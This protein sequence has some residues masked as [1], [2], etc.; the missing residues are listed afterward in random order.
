MSVSVAV[1]GATGRL[2]RVVCDVVDSMSGFELVARL[3]SQDSLDEVGGADIVVDV[4]IPAASESVVQ[5][6]LEHGA[7]VLVGTSGWSADRLTALERTLEGEAA[8]LVVPNFSVGSVVATALSTLAA[9]YFDSVEII[10]AHHQDKIDSPSGTARR[11]AEL[12]AQERAKH[13]GVVSPHSNQTARGEVIDGIPVH[14]LR[15]AGVVA[16]QDVVFGGVAETL[17]IRHD[18]HSA[19]A[20]RQGIE[21]ALRSLVNQT[22]LVVGLHSALGLGQASEQ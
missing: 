5:A 16:Q 4:T 11:T 1:V 6:G 22:G 21:L 18:T 13:G 17:T 2:G 12:I 20:Y 14:S 8:V 19:E 10:E 7:K 3:G 15:L 9:R